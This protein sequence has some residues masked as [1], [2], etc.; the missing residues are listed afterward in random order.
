MNEN[1]R[2]LPS[3]AHHPWTASRGTVEVPGGNGQ[4]IWLIGLLLSALCPRSVCRR[5]ASDLLG[6]DKHVREMTVW[7][8]RTSVSYCTESRLARVNHPAHNRSALIKSSIASQL[9]DSSR[10]VSTK[11]GV[12][13]VPPESDT[14]RLADPSRSKDC[15]VQDEPRD[16]AAETHQ[17]RGGMGWEQCDF[18]QPTLKFWTQA[19][20]SAGLQRPSPFW[21]HSGA[22]VLNA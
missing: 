12:H 17:R 11:R 10:S 14:S 9:V 18:Q 8:M 7:V 20:K 5:H 15:S 13:V 19:L 3:G 22:W 4:R 2:E 6:G 16:C 1:D 21:S